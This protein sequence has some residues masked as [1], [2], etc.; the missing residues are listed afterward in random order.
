MYLIQVLSS[1]LDPDGHSGLRLDRKIKG[2]ERK[3]RKEKQTRK[4]EKEGLRT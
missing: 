4:E 2:K 1:W 3:G